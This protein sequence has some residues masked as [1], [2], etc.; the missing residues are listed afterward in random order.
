MKKLL[1]IF[2]PRSGVKLSKKYLADII[3]LF[4]HHGYICTVHATQC[5]GDAH[6]VACETADLYDLVVC[7]GGDGTLNEA[8]GGLVEGG[9]NIPVGY[10]PTGSTNDFANSMGIPKNIMQA[11]KLIIDGESQT[12]DIGA[13]NDRYFS[14]VASFGAFTRTSYTTPQNIKNAL[15]H[16][17]YVLSGIK[18]LGNIKPIHMKITTA[19][20]DEIEDDYIFGA[21]SNSTSLG[22]ILTLD[23]SV[24]DMND[25]LFEILLVKSPKNILDL[26]ECI[27]ALTSKKYDSRMLVFKTTSAIEIESPPEIDWSLDGEYQQGAEHIVVKNI[28]DAFRLIKK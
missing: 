22:G 23:P 9:H 7:V 15:G 28:K 8:L 20:G 13:F 1:L 18:E 19:E 2:N 16:T 25:G 10:V 5:V 26:N 27:V 3:D 4:C 14:Y 17:A 6:K 12:F 24:V 21:I 11:A